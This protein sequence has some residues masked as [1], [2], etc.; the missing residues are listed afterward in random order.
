MDK[1]EALLQHTDESVPAKANA[2]R[3]TLQFLV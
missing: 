2:L 3:N 1:L